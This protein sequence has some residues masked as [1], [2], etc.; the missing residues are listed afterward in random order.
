V[1]AKFAKFTCPCYDDIGE[2]RAA[3]MVEMIYYLSISL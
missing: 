3:E 1:T 2:I